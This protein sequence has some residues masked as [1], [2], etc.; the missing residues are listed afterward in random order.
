MPC[1]TVLKRYPGN[2]IL[3]PDNIPGGCN[4][5]FNS[6]VVRRGQ[7]D[8]VGV[9]RIEHRNQL[10]RLH[11]GQS[12]DGIAW[13]VDPNPIRLRYDD[14]DFG[15]GGHVYDPRVTL[16]EGTYYITY[17]N[18]TPHG[19][20]I[21]C[22]ETTDFQTFRQVGNL[23]APENRNA[24][25]F[26]EKI[27]GRYARLERPFMSGVDRAH[28]I[29]FAESPDLVHWGRFRHVMAAGGGWGY[30]K[31]GAGAPPIRT[32]DGWLLIYHG[33]R[34]TA[35]GLVY[36]AGAALLDLERPWKV[37]ARPDEYLL[38]PT[39]LYERVGDVP[40]VVFPCA[41]V[42]EPDGEVKVYYGGADTVICLATAPLADL[43]AF[44]LA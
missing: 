27:G 38:A 41:A 32:D 44:C 18:G 7:G 37:V 19:Q 2:P 21:G 11:V 5:I 15:P 43:V 13:D 39:E 3:S 40:N 14:P 28:G 16:L 35:Q 9:F 33:V 26:P 34:H 6:A 24:V 30:T 29:W 1:E 31:I 22:A 12:P 17:A 4:S 10:S 23:S 36:C 42:V 20:V 25:L 8:Y